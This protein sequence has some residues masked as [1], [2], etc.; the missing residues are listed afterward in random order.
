MAISALYNRIAG[1]ATPVATPLV[2]VID[3]AVPK[4]TPSTVGAMVFGAAVAPENARFL[5]PAYEVTVLL[6]ASSAVIVIV[7][8]A[9]PAVVE[10]VLSPPAV[11]RNCDTA[12]NVVVT[13]N[14]TVSATP[15][16]EAIAV[17][18]VPDVVGIV[19]APTLAMPFAFVLAVA[20]VS[21]PV[22][23][24]EL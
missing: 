2:N 7:D 21:L 4:F 24:P 16:F 18:V 20:M 12:P 9:A 11:I 22:R 10:S 15:L 1:A 6:F 19:H 17:A 5:A 14:V 23:R 3:V 13:V 8:A